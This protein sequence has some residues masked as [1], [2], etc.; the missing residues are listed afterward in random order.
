MVGEKKDSDLNTVNTLE[1]LQ[2][3]VMY[4]C[5]ETSTSKIEL[6]STTATKIADAN[7][8]RRFF[9]ATINGSS[10]E[11]SVFIKLQAAS[12]DNS[13]EGIWI[14]RELD[15][16]GS[17]GNICWEMPRDAIYTGEISAIAV[18]GSPDIYVTEY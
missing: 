17:Y 1:S 16:D 10:S 2:S 14:G 15:E 8:D 4:R 13:K 12:V 3:N 7:T 18:S 6:N 5:T 11:V 9:H